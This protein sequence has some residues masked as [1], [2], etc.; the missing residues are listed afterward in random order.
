[1]HYDVFEIERLAERLGFPCEV[2]SA[3]LL[4]RV[5]L[6]S[7]AVLCFQNSTNGEDCRIEF[8]GTPW[9]SHDQLMFAGPTG[10][11]VEIGPLEL[12]PFLAEGRLLI[13]EQWLDGALADRSLIHADFND[14]LKHVGKGEELRVSRAV[15]S[16]RH[17]RVA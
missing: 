11:C 15:V 10:L 8:E 12:L 2:D 3:G 16:P 13:M 17:G 6:K 14:E 9:H 7:H 4:A 5:T 1:M